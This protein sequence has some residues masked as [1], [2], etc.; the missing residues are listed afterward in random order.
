MGK[1]HKAD[2]QKQT[3]PK[4]LPCTNAPGTHP[5]L[6]DTYFQFKLSMKGV[7]LTE[8][9]AKAGDN[10]TSAMASISSGS[11]STFNVQL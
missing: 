2:T 3:L 6:V 1:A 4:S 5:A 10:I 7:P 8:V 11:G 9:F